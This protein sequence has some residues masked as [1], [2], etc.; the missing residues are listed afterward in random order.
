MLLLIENE[1]NKSALPN[2]TKETLKVLLL[3][4]E[5]GL[6]KLFLSHSEI[7]TCLCDF[8]E[9]PL[10]EFRDVDEF[11]QVYNDHLNE[12]YLN[13]SDSNKIIDSD[14]IISFA[15]RA[16]RGEFEFIGA[17]QVYCL[18]IVCIKNALS[19]NTS[20]CIKEASQLVIYSDCLNKFYK[21][22]TYYEELFDKHRSKAIRDFEPL[23]HLLKE[24][25]DVLNGMLHASQKNTILAAVGSIWDDVDSII[26]ENISSN[27]SEPLELANMLE[28]WNS[29]G[30][31]A[32]T[33]WAIKQNLF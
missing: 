21:M 30:K 18:A 6:L 8:S 13:N 11:Y 3:E 12:L 25:A 4:A 27:Y 22:L 14:Y 28:L 32:F 31:R 16:F 23:F 9:N 33:N 1:I 26:E 19:G 24:K 5:T 7:D 15:D 10:L 17:E 29:N 2:E 20:K